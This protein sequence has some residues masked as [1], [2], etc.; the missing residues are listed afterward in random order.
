[1]RGKAEIGAAVEPSAGF[2]YMLDRS[3]DSAALRSIR[4]KREPGWFGPSCGRFR[5][6]HATGVRC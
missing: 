3:P 1:M 2:G 6:I 5:V 4:I